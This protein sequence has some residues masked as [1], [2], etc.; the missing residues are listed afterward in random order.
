MIGYNK[1]RVANIVPIKFRLSLWFSRTKATLPSSISF[2][3]NLN[4]VSDFTLACLASAWRLGLAYLSLIPYHTWVLTYQ[5]TIDIA[6]FW[7]QT[8]RVRCCRVG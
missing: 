4:H 8:L 5:Q 7:L 2:S 6:R 1:Y 3:H